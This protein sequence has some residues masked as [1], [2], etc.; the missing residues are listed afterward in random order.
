MEPGVDLYCRLL[1]ASYAWHARGRPTLDAGAVTALA[2]NLYLV[3][4]GLRPDYELPYSRNPVSDSPF[5]FAELAAHAGGGVVQFWRAPEARPA[6]VV[7]CCA[8]NR[9]FVSWVCTAANTR[10]VLRVDALGR[11]PDTEWIFAQLV[12]LRAA[13]APLGF[14]AAAE[15][16]PDDA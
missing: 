15:I 11:E 6:R 16:E 8:S 4:I 10:Y 14:S 2:L 9:G 3:A 5:P 12:A 13:L 7:G 1:G